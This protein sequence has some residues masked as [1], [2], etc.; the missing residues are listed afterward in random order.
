MGALVEWLKTLWRK[1]FPKPSVI[2]PSAVNERAPAANI[3]CPYCSAD[4]TEALR[5]IPIT[6]SQATLVCSGKECQQ[7]MELYPDGR[8]GW[9]VPHVVARERI[10]R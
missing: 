8:W 5:F 10:L 7:Q 4:Y 2:L 3:S 9:L 6:T 1:W